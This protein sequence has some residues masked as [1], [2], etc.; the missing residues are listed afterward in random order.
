MRENSN[1]SRIL[2][3]G[4]V[5]ELA[6]GKIS[7]KISA[8]KICARAGAWALAGVIVLGVSGCSLF[9]YVQRKA[10][11]GN[12]SSDHWYV[13][14]LIIDDEIFYAPQVLAFSAHATQE[15]DEGTT[16]SDS[17]DKEAP[18]PAKNDSKDS[19]PQKLGTLELEREEIDAIIASYP[20]DRADEIAHIDEVAT[21]S[22]DTA[23]GRIS[24]QSGCGSYFASYVWSDR[25]HI[26]IS[27]GSST[28]KLC[29]P[30]E[31]SRFEFRF[32]RDLE[33]GFKIIQKHK[34]KLILESSKIVIH[35]YRDPESS[36]D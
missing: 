6:R 34:D 27:A 13:Q 15:S 3:R 36:Q 28:R 2:A 14:K 32:I 12:I 22:F 17:G 30:S 11:Q 9:E 29:S 33:G 4:F 26:N 21:L 31:V 35:L 8:G 5:R 7:G 24:G 10:T 18:K 25:E 1:G 16:A 20:K 23:Q 19:K